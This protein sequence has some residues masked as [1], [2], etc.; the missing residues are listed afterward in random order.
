MEENKTYLDAKIS[1]EFGRN[2]RE[3]GFRFAYHNTSTYRLLS[4]LLK[5][6]LF[7]SSV[8]ICGRV[9]IVL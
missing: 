5:Y 4:I 2:E 7:I 9:L 3:L 8:D 6:L 1:L